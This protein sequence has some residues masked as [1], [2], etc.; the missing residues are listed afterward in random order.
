MAD[1]EF[2][3]ELDR[4]GGEKL[5][6][7]FAL[8]DGKDDVQQILVTDVLAGSLA[9]RA[10]A[11]NA[12]V[13]NGVIC[14][15]DELVRLNG[16][17]ASKL[18]LASFQRELGLSQV[19]LTF[20]RAD[21]GGEAKQLVDQGGANQVA[22]TKGAV[23]RRSRLSATGVHAVAERTWLAAFYHETGGPTRWRRN[24]RWLT[25]SPSGEWYGVGT[26]NSGRIDA[27]CLDEN[28]LNGGLRASARFMCGGVLHPSPVS[29][30]KVSLCHNELCG[31][32]PG[33]IFTPPLAQCYLSYNQFTGALPPQLFRC[34]TLAVLM[35]QGNQLVG[36]IPDSISRLSLLRGLDLS[37]NQFDGVLPSAMGQLALLECLDV[38]RNM[39]SGPLPS[40]LR[41][42][43]KLEFLDVSHNSFS[44]NVPACVGSLPQLRLLDV[45]DNCLE[46]DLPPL[47]DCKNL[48]RDHMFFGKQRNDHA[49]RTT[50]LGQRQ[51]Q[52][53]PAP[54][55]PPPCST[56][57]SESARL[58]CPIER[59]W[60]LLRNLNFG[61]W[62]NVDANASA[63]LVDAEIGL[64]GA[65][66]QVVF[67]DAAQWC[68]Q[69]LEHSELVH[70]LV[71]D[72]VD[73]SPALQCMS[74]LH[75]ITLHRVTSTDETIV[76]WVTDFSS[77]VKAETIVDARYK[78]LEALD[79]MRA[80][81]IAV[82]AASAPPHRLR[83]PQQSYD[84][85]ITN[86][87]KD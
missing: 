8:P 72:V 75:A 79:D 61:W 70:T 77:D 42:C 57:V 26:A 21:V 46:G 51:Y 19:T 17:L 3:F 14:V 13:A 56:R 28:G 22:T 40:A 82:D 52:R 49:A 1:A 87:E 53:C 48:A 43:S 11:L 32:V 12:N 33:A 29:L 2:S 20:A 50:S 60:A 69:L 83:W 9:A 66:A 85:K 63:P 84:S 35:V 68:L 31:E 58:P 4:S 67:R 34:K 15:G 36:T 16:K 6:I 81:V 41:K 74:Q 7:T 62:R 10:R 47:A 37:R 24:D 27:I 30:V 45:S 78:R 54:N 18:D 44:G 73:A 38:S 64:C 86:Y 65:V 71:F 55:T 23:P 39:F 59:A 25:A 5:G 80:C 76:E